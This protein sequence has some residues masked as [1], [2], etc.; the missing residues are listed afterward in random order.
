MGTK[1]L[2]DTNAI[3]EF[4]GGTLPTAANRWLEGIIDDDSH[5]VSIINKIELLGFNAPASEMIILQDFIDCTTVIPLDD[6]VAA[7]TIELRKTHRI[8]LPDAVIASTALVYDLQLITRNT[9]DFR[10]IAGLDVVNPA[11]ITA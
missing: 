10:H 3:I 1:Y 7:K 8:K 5:H 6:L 4:L 2:L 9:G 11:E